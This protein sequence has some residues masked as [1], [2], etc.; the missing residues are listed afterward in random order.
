MKRY[1]L[2]PSALNLYRECPRCFWLEKRMGIRRPRGIFPSLPGGMDTVIK[3]YFDR[4]RKMGELPPGLKGRVE[5]RLFPDMETIRRWRSWRTTDLCYRDPILGAT[6]SGALDDCLIRGNL[7]IPLDYKTRGS[8]LRDDPRRYY[9]NQL[10]CYCLILEESGYRTAGVSYL[11]YYW[12]TEVRENGIVK[13]EV[14]PLRV[15][16]D[17]EAARRTFEDAIRLLSG[18]IPDPS[19]DCDYC[20]LVERVA[21]RVPGG[22]GWRWDDRPVPDARNPGAGDVNRRRRGSA[23]ETRR[24]EG[25]GQMSLNV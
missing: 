11:V 7:H 2:S 18:A 4:Y 21:R 8:K 17:V 16:T 13:F 3:T 24:D 5:G 1:V 10:D 25:G 6:L 14:T 15:E 19:P 23:V 9:Q 20:M 22:N 12:P